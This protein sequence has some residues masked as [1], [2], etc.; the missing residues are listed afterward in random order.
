M[1]KN[2]PVYV[3]FVLL[4]SGMTLLAQDSTCPDIVSQA[5]QV[6]ADSCSDLGRNEA[7]YG[8]LSISAEFRDEA[9]GVTF[10]QAGD[11][12][13]VADIQTLT[14]SAL[15]SP[16]EWGV[17]LMA[18]QA[19]LPDTLPGQN[20]TLLLFGET[21][22]EFDAELPP[23]TLDITLT[24]NA[25]VRSGPGSGY[26]VIDGLVRETTI[27]VVGR[28]EFGDWLQVELPEE[29]GIGWIFDSAGLATADGDILPVVDPE[30]GETTETDSQFGLG[31]AF[32]V[33]TALVEPQCAEAPQDGILIQTPIGVGEVTL[34]VNEVQIDLGSTIFIQA[35]AG[36]VMYVTLLEGSARV[37]SQG[38]TVSI[39]PGARAEILLDED[40][41]ASSPPEIITFEEDLTQAL[42]V[43]L[44]PEEIEIAVALTEEELEEIP[45]VSR[46]SLIWEQDVYF[47]PNGR[48]ANASSGEYTFVKTGNTLQFAS[49]GELVLQPGTI[50]ES[51]LERAFSGDPAGTAT[52][53]S[54]IRVLSSYQFTVDRLSIFNYDDGYRCEIESVYMATYIGQELPEE[55]E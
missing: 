49:H 33:R 32:T 39:P 4:F 23:P 34:N 45:W 20:V 14:L 42:P 8:N 17:A 13:G 25:N 38:V 27:T 43:E 50:L 24:G 41:N 3:F 28:N 40:G 54:K 18:L 44:L 15:Q 46:W 55:F 31:Q 52:E 7:C 36:H 48:Y 29:R 6:T 1:M 11:V 51:N 21:E 26:G 37:T 53:I 30:S 2:Y 19:N 10:E 9:E 12:V 35:E 16:D 5:L 47:C 22:I